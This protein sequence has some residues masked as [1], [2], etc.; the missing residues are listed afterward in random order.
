MSI[1][2]LNQ[3]TSSVGTLKCIIKPEV[4]TGHNYSNTLTNSHNTHTRGFFFSHNF[5]T[6]NRWTEL[7]LSPYTCLLSTKKTWLAYPPFSPSY[8]SLPPGISP[9][10]SPSHPHI[11]SHLPLLPASLPQQAHHCEPGVSA[12]GAKTTI[13]SA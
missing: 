8:S 11:F 2:D 3:I 13:I 6:F 12:G 1:L 5:S 7:V 9:A 10:L 4:L